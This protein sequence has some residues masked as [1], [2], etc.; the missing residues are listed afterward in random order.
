MVLNLIYSKGIN[1]LI[2]ILLGYF[3]EILDLNI[4]A[5]FCNLL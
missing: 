4:K 1:G 2:I 5:V 3:L